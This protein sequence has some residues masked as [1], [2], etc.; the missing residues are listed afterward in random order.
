MSK[1][2]IV[3]WLL[4]RR[5]NLRCKYCAIVKNYEGKPPEY[6][7]MNHYLLNEMLLTSDIILGLAK[8]HSHNPECFHIFYGGEPMLR[9]DLPS[10]ISYCN[11]NNIPYTIISNNTPEVQ[12]MIKDLFDYT[13]IKG[14]TASIDPVLENKNVMD[15][16][17][18]SREGFR[19]LLE[20]KKKVKDVVAEITVANDDVENLYSL[21]KFLSGYKI[22]SDITFVDIAKS[23][24]YDFSNVTDEKILVQKTDEVVEQIQLI[25]DDNTLD[26]HMKD[27][28]LPMILD[29]LPSNYDCKLED[30]IHNLT[31]DADGSIRLCL[32]IKGVFQEKIDLT[33]LFTEN[34]SEVA[35]SA[36]QAL[37]DNKEKYCLLCNHTCQMMSKYIDDENLSNDDL[38][39]KDKREEN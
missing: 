15:R 4:T 38:I 39:H 28:L 24:Y 6:P 32:R 13:E 37:I 2:R 17:I 18:K 12:P 8:L 14:F 20:L 34:Y 3:N 25:M 9:K 35:E 30:G 7:D 27:I 26:I 16:I 31:I 23:P 5:C 36:K 11:A 10:I 19:S 22:N 21:V 29:F 1:I 33:N